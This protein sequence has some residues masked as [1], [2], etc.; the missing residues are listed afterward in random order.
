[1]GSE[2]FDKR[3][4]VDSD[5]DPFRDLLTPLNGVGTITQDLGFNNGHQTIRLADHCIPGQSVRVLLD[6]QLWKGEWRRME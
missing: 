5:E 6:R 3:Y 2:R 1:M 4:L